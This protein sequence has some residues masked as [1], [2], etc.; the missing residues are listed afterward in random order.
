MHQK[1][2]LEGRFPSCAGRHRLH[3][4]RPSQRKTEFRCG[5]CLA[6]PPVPPG[7][8]AFPLA[9]DD[10]HTR[11]WLAAQTGCTRMGAFHR[12]GI[13]VDSSPTPGPTTQTS[14]WQVSESP[15]AGASMQSSGSPPLQRFHLQ[16]SVERHPV[17]RRRR[18][19]VAEP[20]GQSPHEVTSYS[21]FVPLLGSLQRIRVR[22]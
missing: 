17:D 19:A 15:A 16:E 9:D 2:R 8:R 1:T 4:R 22:A 11:A 14:P 3:G 20:A 5:A 6:P 21:V 7:S 10:K 18:G 12:A 13:A